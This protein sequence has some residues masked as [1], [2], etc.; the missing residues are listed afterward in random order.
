MDISYAFF[1]EAIQ[2]TSDN[3]VNILRGEDLHTIPF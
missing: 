1:A 2:L 3:R